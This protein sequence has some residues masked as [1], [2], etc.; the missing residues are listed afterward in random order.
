[1][2][3]TWK[4]T[5]N[6]FDIGWFI[7]Y[8]YSNSNRKKHMENFMS[9]SVSWHN[10]NKMQPWTKLLV[11]QNVSSMQGGLWQ[12]LAARVIHFTGMLHFS[13]PWV[14]TDEIKG[15]MV[16]TTWE[17]ASFLSDNVWNILVIWINCVG[18]SNQYPWGKIFSCHIYWTLFPLILV[19]VCLD[20]NISNVCIQ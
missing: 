9:K 14:G 19:L 15:N 13:D 16:P 20:T 11:M 2:T 18:I 17:N 12:W 5:S 10:W 1:M 3:S 6:L 7:A 4:I 8:S